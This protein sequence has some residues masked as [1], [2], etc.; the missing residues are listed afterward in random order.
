MS[1]AIRA[2]AM[3]V[4]MIP[5]G[6]VNHVGTSTSELLPVA[7]AAQKSGANPAWPEASQTAPPTGGSRSRTRR[8]RWVNAIPPPNTRLWKT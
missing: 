5:N 6:V 3:L 4:M 1:I 7:A 2:L 8:R